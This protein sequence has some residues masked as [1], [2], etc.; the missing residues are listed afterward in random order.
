M[1]LLPEIQKVFDGYDLKPIELP[2]GIKNVYDY[3]REYPDAE[4][5]FLTDKDDGYLYEKYSANIPKGWYGFAIGVPIVP[6]YN[7]IIDKVLEICIAND[8]DF[9]IHQI[10]FKLG[11]MRFYVKTNVIEDIDEIELLIMSKMYDKALIY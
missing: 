4:F 8:P 7:E 9:E 6:E 3:R 10:K 11:G 2:E 5:K 1:K